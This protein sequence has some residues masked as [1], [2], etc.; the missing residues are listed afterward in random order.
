MRDARY[1]QGMGLSIDDSY[2]TY[3][4]SAYPS[5]SNGFFLGHGGSTLNRFVVFI[6]LFFSYDAGAI[7]NC[8]LAMVFMVYNFFLLVHGDIIPLHSTQ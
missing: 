6:Y 7:S 4:Y 2:C 1:V 5:V 3:Q 8:I